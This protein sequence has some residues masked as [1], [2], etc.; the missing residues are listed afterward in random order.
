M[1]RYE[2]KS[3]STSNG[4]YSGAQAAEDKLPPIPDPPRRRTVVK[5]TLEPAT[6]TTMEERMMLERK[7]NTHDTNRQAGR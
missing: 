5:G 3:T 7:P 1:P 2:T 6:R 4:E